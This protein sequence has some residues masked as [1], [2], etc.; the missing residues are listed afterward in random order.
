V[1]DLISPFA[2]GHRNDTNDLDANVAK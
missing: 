2:P 1:E